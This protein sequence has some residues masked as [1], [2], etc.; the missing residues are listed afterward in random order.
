MAISIYL[1]ELMLMMLNYQK[2][3]FFFI[4]KETKKA[5]KFYTIKN[6]IL[7]DNAIK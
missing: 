2:L 7:E 6:L 3:D 1:Q 5:S 4:N